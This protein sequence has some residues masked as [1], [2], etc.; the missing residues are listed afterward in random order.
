[1]IQHHYAPAAIE[2]LI[3]DV[4]P[5]VPA[6]RYAR[7]RF[8]QAARDATELAAM[9]Q[10]YPQVRYQPLD[11]HYVLLQYL[12]VLDAALAADLCSGG[13]GWRGAAACA[14][15][16]CLQPTPALAQPLLSWRERIPVQNRW[17]IAL[18]LAE[19]AGAQASVDAATVEAVRTLRA[20]LAPL[21]R[22]RVTL[23]RAPA[24]DRLE[25]GRAAVRKAYQAGGLSAARPLALA[26]LADA[27]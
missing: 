20:C 7:Q 14:W 4:L 3:Y 25:A 10:R 26:L 23:P 5:P 2:R 22:P 8:E 18:A 17:L 19:A 24:A 27:R 13:Y 15:L 16:V 6:E 11:Q 21:P 9:L 1:M 12:A